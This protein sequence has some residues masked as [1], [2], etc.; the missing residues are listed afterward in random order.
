MGRFIRKKFVTQNDPNCQVFDPRY[1]AV[2]L[3]NIFVT[4]M[5]PKT[6]VSYHKKKFFLISDTFEFW[7]VSLD[8][9]FVTQMTP[10]TQISY[11]EKQFSETKNSFQKTENRNYGRTNSFPN[12]EQFWDNQ[13]TLLQKQKTGPE[14]VF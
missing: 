3:D 4:Q 2:L 7:A 9:F 14:T 5:T 6:Q 10:K 12:G 11:H 8:T 13:N 1:W